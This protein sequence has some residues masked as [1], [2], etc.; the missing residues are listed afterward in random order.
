LRS[1][2]VYFSDLK[3]DAQKRLCE[4]FGTTPEK[5]NWDK[6]IFPLF[7]LEREEDDCDN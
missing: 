7:V 5:E 2:N 4:R 6:D 1:F 3:R